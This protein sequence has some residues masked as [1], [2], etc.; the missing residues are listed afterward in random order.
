MDFTTASGEAHPSF[1]KNRHQDETD[2]ER[3]GRPGLNEILS[4][5]GSTPDVATA[6]IETRKHPVPIP[7]RQKGPQVPE[8]EQKEFEP[9]DFRVGHNIGLHHI[10]IAALDRDCEESYA[11]RNRF[12]RKTFRTGRASKPESHSWYY[13]TDGV[14]PFLQLRDG[15]MMIELRYGQ[16]KQTVIP[17]SVHPSGEPY[18]V[19]ADAPVATI[20]AEELERGVRLEAAAC[21][22]AR[23]YAN[24][25]ERHEWGL[26][27]A[28]YLLRNGVSEEDALELMLA[29]RGLQPEGWTKETEKG[30]QGVIKST[31]KK[32]EEGGKVAGGGELRKGGHK[33]LVDKLPKI[34]GWEDKREAGPLTDEERKARADEV[35]PV[36]AELAAWPNI[37]RLFADALHLRGVAGETNQIRLL[38]LIV[39]SRRLKK[40]VNI[41]VK[42]ASSSGKSYLVEEVLGGFPDSAYYA[43]SAMSEKALI[44]LDEDMR[45]RFLVI[46]EASGMAGDMQTY[47]IRTLLSEGKIRYQTAEATSKGVKPK[48]LEMEGPT[49][50]IVTTT[51][52][53]MHPENETRLFSLLVTDSREQTADILM[54]MADEDREPVSMDRWRALQTWLEGQSSEVYIPYSKELASL[55][56]PVAVRLR[57]DFM[58]VLQLIR[59]HAVLH[60]HTREKDEKG[61]ILA[62]FEDYAVVRELVAP[63]VAE[64]VDAGV[65]QTVK[66]TVAMVKRLTVDKDEDHVSIRRLA[67]ALELDK[68]ATSRRWQTAR[69]AGYLKNLEESRGKTAKIALGEP[70]PEEVEI[71]PTVEALR[72]CCSVAVQTEGRYTPHDRCTSAEGGNGTATFATNK[73]Q[74]SDNYAEHSENGSGDSEGV[75]LPPNDTA[76]VQHFN[77]SPDRGEPEDYFEPKVVHYT[78]APY[79]VYVGRSGDRFRRVSSSK[80]GNP[81]KMD[82]YNKEGEFVKRD[83]TREEVIAMFEAYLHG[84][85]Q[86]YEGETFDGRHLMADLHELRGL[87][88]ACHCAPEPCHADVLLR[89]ANA[90]AVDQ[91]L[92]DYYWEQRKRG[93]SHEQA[94]SMVEK[95]EEGDSPKVEEWRAEWQ[96][97]FDACRDAESA[98]A[99]IRELH[100]MQGTTPPESTIEKGEDGRTTIYA[101][102]DNG[103]GATIVYLAMEK[104]PIGIDLETT[105]LNPEDGL[106]RLITLARGDLTCLIDCFY[107]DPTPLLA[108]FGETKARNES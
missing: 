90:P 30:I 16:G 21:L 104:G 22:I 83:G 88:L 1:D 32:L 66:D 41:A 33:E 9:S 38:Y 27:L 17:P 46:Y 107:V 99:L 108:K 7:K 94:L 100:E 28:G 73:Q 86:N 35:W 23:H 79:D 105:A 52:T 26:Q 4:Q 71:L 14:P 85:I 48:L 72:E 11:L 61:R 36:C 2:A 47:L 64:G 56:P 62:T 96:E 49:G 25:G 84:P 51:Q 42:G 103:L 80:W 43:L 29:A 20:S 67:D 44:Y 45:H 57:R 6:L 59:S 97:R 13:V 98:R 75:Y 70:L 60:Q 91:T 37:T 77:A 95:Y 3:N 15:K 101:T 89:L 34:L 50:L 5:G 53:K 76:T 68:S 40:P 82:Y 87:V 12:L 102:D 63:L 55:I 39:N 74:H 10:N 65:P 106:I 58:A 93:C 81:F 24:P 8:W 78:R 69:D 31:A 19:G 92:D 54:A 18:V